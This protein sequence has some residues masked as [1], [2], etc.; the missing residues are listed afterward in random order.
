M[1]PIIQLFSFLLRISKDI[2][3]SRATL[4]FVT[5]AGI[6]S[7]V[8]STAMIG[9]ITASVARQ[10]PVEEL[11]WVFLALVI[12]LPIFRFFSQVLLINLNQR[13]LRTL[14]VR[15][16]RRIL[17]APLRHLEKTGPSR[18]LATMTQDVGTVVEALSGLPGLFMHLAIVVSALTYLGMVSLPVLFYITA[19]IVIGIV[20][21]QLPI[22]K[23]MG[24]MQRS[25][26]LFD[27]M[28]GYIRAAVEGTKELKMHRN[29]RD[30][31]IGAFD[32]SVEEFQ[33]QGKTGSVIF[34]AAASWGHVLFFVVIG[35]LVFVVP[36]FQ[37]VPPDVLAQYTIILFFMMTPLEMLMNTLPMLGRAAVAVK[38]VEDLGF[39]LDNQVKERELPS[40]ETVSPQWRSMELAGVCHSYHRENEEESFQLGPINLAFQPGEAVFLVGGNGSGKTTLA[41]LLLGLYAPES[42]EI[43]LN[44]QAITDENREWYREHFSAVFVDFF[45]F[46][47]LLGIEASSLD[48][49]ARK[50]L[51]QLHLEQKVQ[52]KGGELSTVELSQGQRKRLAL[53]TAY[54]EDRPIYL[55]DEWAA[56]QDP[57]F[58]EIFYLELLPELKQRGKTVFVISHDDRYY[59]VADRIIKL[60]YGKVVSD[61]SM[62]DF[63][64]SMTTENGSLR[65]SGAAG[66]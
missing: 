34:V 15:L 46:E 59:Y 36:R 14:R 60:D 54:L 50:Y 65:Q 32:Q 48:D 42:G 9:V 3:R 16:V 66:I 39:T 52:V 10:R 43:R 21:Y 61:R 4:A 8:A 45:I 5:F 27:N 37:P 64:D 11:A 38:A 58:K 1:R 56:D 23:A 31:F 29:R 25:R 6:V 51:R 26:Q 49:N 63:L 44:G 17:A 2:P 41:K 33:Q 30:A 20:T 47:K 12:L 53:L 24:Y 35:L 7:G 57:F 62:A 55:F 22:I 18:L 40:G 19:F 13:S 28:T